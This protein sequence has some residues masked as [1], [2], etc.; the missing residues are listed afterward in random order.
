MHPFVNIAIKAARTA[1]RT[2]TRY[3]ERLDRITINEKSRNDFVSEVDRLAEKD[4]IDTI[5]LAYPQHAIVS[6]ESPPVEGNE[7]CWII[8]PLDGTMNYLHSYPQFCVSIAVQQRDQLLAAVIYDPLRNELFS[9]ARGE[10]ANLNNRR[11]RVSPCDRLDKALLGTGFPFRNESFWPT[12]SKML[13]ALY[14][15]ISDIR[16]SG[17]AAL[18]LAYVAAGRLDGFWEGKLAAWDIAAGALLIQEAG[19]FTKDFEGKDH[20]LESGNIVAGNTKILKAILQ[21][22]EPIL[23]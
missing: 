10:G 5:R 18:D 8:D 6:E 17:S 1:S 22:I 3:M 11:L 21:T 7:F 23:L 4:I 19:G 14:P 20:Y 9:A 12:Y 15:K 13:E 2:I 16:R